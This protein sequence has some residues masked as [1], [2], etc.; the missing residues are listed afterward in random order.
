MHPQSW[1]DSGGAI[2]GNAI[3]GALAHKGWVQDQHAPAVGPAEQSANAQADGDSA[4]ASV[5]QDV[6]NLDRSTS[7]LV[8]DWGGV[9]SSLASLRSD[10]P[11]FLSDAADS[12]ASHCDT[13]PDIPDSPDIR[14]DSLLD[15]LRQLRSDIARTRSDEAA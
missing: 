4:A 11:G 14:A 2:K 5:S 6:D 1:R 3:C 12:K 15:G 10:L 7:Q 13:F 9:R 8:S